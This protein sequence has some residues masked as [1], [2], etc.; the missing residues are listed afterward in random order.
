ALA[1]H[2]LPLAPGRLVLREGD[3]RAAQRI[4]R[5]RRAEELRMA[6]PRR[7]SARPSQIIRS[8]GDD[9]READ[10]CT[11][12]ILGGNGDL[13]KRKLLPAIYQLAKDG[14]MP[15]GC[16]ILGVARDSMN[17]DA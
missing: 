5:P 13:A 3:R 10:P 2:A 12:V 9:R 8:L 16:D 15:D 14:L 1:A 4:R 6:E 7:V 11:V 17:D